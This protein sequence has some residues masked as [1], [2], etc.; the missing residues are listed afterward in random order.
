MNS[1][2]PKNHKHN[3]NQYRA[4][5]HCLTLNTFIKNLI[6]YYKRWLERESLCYIKPDYQKTNS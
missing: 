4:N 5:H 6:L 2:G 1:E 3:V